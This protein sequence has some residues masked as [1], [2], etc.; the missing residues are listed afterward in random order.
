MR[1]RPLFPIFIDLSRLRCLVVGGGGVAERKAKKLAAAGARV[2]VV[3]TAARAGIQRLA[4]RKKVKL[5]RRA[6]S[7]ADLRGAFIVVCATDDAAANARV[8]AAAARRNILTNVADT[9]AM[10]DFF[11]P[12]VV[13]RGQLQI[14][15]STGGSSPAAARRIAREL[16]RRYGRE[17]AELLS[18]MRSLRARVIARVPQKNRRAVFA[19]MSRP[20]VLRLLRRGR[21]AAARCAMERAIQEATPGGGPGR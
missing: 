12:A 20:S 11:L 9:P 16:E 2:T 14:A 15:I 7:R 8:A 3:A 21:R 19:A 17:Y 1:S 18:M 13:R 6:F 4:R 5:I 10:C